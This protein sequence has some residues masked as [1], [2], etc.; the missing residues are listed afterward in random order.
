M[1]YCQKSYL[2]T[3]STKKSKP[4]RLSVEWREGVGLRYAV[5]VGSDMVELAFLG[6]DLQMVQGV[7]GAGAGAHKGDVLLLGKGHGEV[8]LDE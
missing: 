2:R 7:A 6:E 5:A 3:N 8:E 1:V 4:S